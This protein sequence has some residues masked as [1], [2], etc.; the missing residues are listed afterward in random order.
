MADVNIFFVSELNDEYFTRHFF[1][2]SFSTG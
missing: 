2:N 1:K